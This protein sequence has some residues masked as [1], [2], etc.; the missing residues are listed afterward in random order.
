VSCVNLFAGMCKNTRDLEDMFSDALKAYFK[1]RGTS[2]DVVISCLYGYKKLLHAEMFYILQEEI[3]GN[4]FK[5]E[6]QELNR[7]QQLCLSL[8][9]KKKD[10]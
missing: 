5:M 7:I 4:V 2:E 10:I 9:H 1:K 3:T 6:V 8:L